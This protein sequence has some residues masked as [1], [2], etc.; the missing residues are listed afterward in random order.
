MSSQYRLRP[1]QIEAVDAVVRALQAPA[2]RPVSEGGLRAQIVAATGTGKSLI[3]VHAA[4]ELRAER[5]LVLVPTLDLLAQMATVWREGGRTGRLF[6]ACSLSEGEALGVPCTTD[7]VELVRWLGGGGRVTLFATYAAVGLGV[8]ERAHAAGLGAWD[9]V[10]VDEAHR[11][12]GALGKPWAGVHDNGRLPAVRRLY[13][14]ATPRLWEVAAA[15]VAGSSGGGL[16]EVGRAAGGP[17][18]VVASMD[19]EAV[20]GPVVYRLTLSDAI[21]RGLIAQYQ[22][23]CVDIADPQLQ[24]AQLIGQDARTDTVRGARLAALQTAVLKTGAERKLRRLLTF[25]YRT[26]EAEAFASGLPAVAKA[27]W[28][29]APEAYPE[30][31]AVWAQWLYGEHKPAHRRRVLGEFTAGTT[32]E[33]TVMERCVLASVRVLGE[34]VDTK[35][36]DA[37]VFADV[38]GSTVDIV[39]AVGRAL[40]MQPGEGKV[41]SLVVP[42]FLSP[43]EEPDDM[44]SSRSYEGLIKV[45]TALRAHDTE[46]VEQLATPQAA[47]R[48]AA[49]TAAAG[50]GQGA[51]GGVSSPAGGLLAFSAPRDPA[52]LAAFISLRVLQPETEFWRRGLQAALTYH[53]DHQDLHVPYGHRTSDGFPLGVWITRQ[54]QAHT[55]GHLNTERVKQ[56]DELGMI[57]NHAD[58]AFTEG[59]AAARGWAAEH[60]HLLAPT[61]ATWQG[62]PIGQWLKNQRAAARRSTAGH[63]RKGPGL[64]RERREALEEIDPAWCPAWPVVWQRCFHLARTYYTAGGTLPDRDGQLIIQGEDI[65]RWIRAQQTQWD[66]LTTVQQWLLTEILGITATAG[67]RTLA[68][69]AAKPKRSRAQIWA[70][71]LTA[72]RQYAEREGHLNV[73]RSHVEDVAGTGHALGVFIAN[74]RARRTGLAPERIAELDAL[75]IRW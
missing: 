23:V 13:M 55:R 17:G 10:V 7:P 72:A 11:T 50:G 27:L 53:G 56:L 66:T 21:E 36:C 54:R 32:A 71:S 8:L 22:V 4:Y 43:G 44:L 2:E 37:V 39:Q 58:I 57:W 63:D 34:G 15:E 69:G 75:G 48:R 73:P 31:G 9:L 65:G 60:G 38:L 29:S 74:Q 30:P 59:L 26:S 41:A 25:H 14:T 70:A 16:G 5:V 51:V 1:H 52:Q 61:D 6:G 45:L 68:L 3:A 24:A 62:H 47:S 35:N 67:E 18:Q 49:T 40:R 20:F 12:S 33:G 64:D 46:A 42:V 19:D 28:D